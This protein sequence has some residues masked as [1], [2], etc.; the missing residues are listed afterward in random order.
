M[1]F[2]QAN[3]TVSINVT[4]LTYLVWFTGVTAQL[5]VSGNAI[6]Y[7]AGR[8]YFNSSMYIDYTYTNNTSNTSYWTLSITPNVDIYNL[9]IFGY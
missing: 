6:L 7:N 8:V 1:E 2:A 9:N 3:S 5:R 4:G